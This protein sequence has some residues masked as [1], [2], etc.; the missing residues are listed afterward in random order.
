VTV[1]GLL[2]AFQL[3]ASMQWPERMPRQGI[4]VVDFY[5]QNLVA[6]KR[7]PVLD[8]QFEKI[9][10]PNLSP[11]ADV[12]DTFRATFCHVRP[13]S[14]AGLWACILLRTKGQGKCTA[15]SLQDLHVVLQQLCS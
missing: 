7:I 2:Q 6:D 10:Q 13:P 11:S 3:T 12:N 1:V 15:A 5:T 9:Y 8:S 14:R 4:L